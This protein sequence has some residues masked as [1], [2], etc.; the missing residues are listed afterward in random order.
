MRTEGFSG[1]PR[2]ERPRGTPDPHREPLA[3]G[4]YRC[5]QKAQSLRNWASVRPHPRADIGRNREQPAAGRHARLCRV[6]SGPY[7]PLER[8]NLARSVETTL[9]E[10]PPVEL[11][12][13]ESFVGAG[14]YAIYY[15]GPF[16]AY[17]PISSAEYRVPIY[18]GKADPAGARKGLVDPGAAAGPVLF[19]RIG[20]HSKS[21]EAAENLDIDDFRVRYLVVEDIF[22]GMGEQLLIQQFKPLWNVHVSGFGLHDPGAGRHGSERSEW[23]EMHPGRPWYS[24][25][26]QAET[27]EEIAAKI[28]AAFEAG[29]AATTDDPS[30]GASEA[31]T[32]TEDGETAP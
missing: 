24:K 7:N 32:A 25:M 18:V 16:P 11:P 17:A 23:D 29:E 5:S 3:L 19:K 22:I 12:L 30:A 31:E 28:A 1:S 8:V 9:L 13:T 4:V 20:D 10:Q 27:P 14:L 6:T 15:S 21:I 2:T 26:T